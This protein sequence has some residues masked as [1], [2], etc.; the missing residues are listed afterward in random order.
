VLARADD[1]RL[2]HE[3][4]N[5]KERLEALRAKR[6]MGRFPVLRPGE[7]ASAYEALWRLALA[8]RPDPRGLRDR[9]ATRLWLRT[10]P[11]QRE[12]AVHGR[13][14][15]GLRL[16][17]TLTGPAG[18]P[19][20]SHPPQGHVVVKSVHAPLALE[21]LAHGFPE[22]RVVVVLRHPAN[23]LSSWRELRLPDQDRALD[24]HPRIREGVLAAWGVGPPGADPVSRAAWHVCLLTAALVDAAGRHP[25][26]LVVEHEDLC[27]RPVERFA[28]MAGELGM[29][30]TDDAE[31]YLRAS[32]IG[33]TGFAIQ[34][35]ANEQPGRWRSRLT[36]AVVGVLASTMRQFPL[37]ERWT[38]ELVHPASRPAHG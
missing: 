7:S 18:T 5:E 38:D 11:D 17:L 10:S 27:R 19:T 34:R 23:I 33:G 28:E 32:D 13:L 6:G 16:A 1:S 25:G 14:T 35:R 30:W 15:V 4:D 24:R 36:S 22:M 8:G 21:W 12:A 31:A 29:T 37:L 26:W 2:L 20:A 9:F 3:P